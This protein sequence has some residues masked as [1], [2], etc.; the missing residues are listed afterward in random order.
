MVK[1]WFLVLIIVFFIASP[2]SVFGGSDTVVINAFRLR[3]SEKSTDEFVELLN[4]SND[5]ISL[6]GW[7][8]SKKNSSGTNNNLLTTFPE[9]TLEAGEK[10]TI[11]HRDFSGS[12]D[13]NYSTLSY[14][15]AEDNAIV[16]YADAGKTEVDKVGWGKSLIFEGAPLPNPQPDEIWE[17]KELGLD[18]DNN[19]A[20]FQLRDI[21]SN[22]SEPP[23]TE[24]GNNTETI[25]S[26]I[27][28]TELMPNPE[29]TDSGKEWVEFFNGGPDLNLAGYSLSDKFG[30][31]KT[32]YFPAGFSL[33]SEQYFVF[34]LKGTGISLNNDGDV[35]EIK[36][37]NGQIVAS[38]GP[39]YGTAKEGL[40]WAFNGAN[41]QW[42]KVPTPG[43][44][45][46]IEVPAV[47]VKTKTVKSK[48]VKKATLPKASVKGST[49]ATDDLFEAREQRVNENDKKIGMI[50]IVLALV[51]GLVYTVYTNWSQIREVYLA[52]RKKYHQIRQ[53][54]RQKTKK[55]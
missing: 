27:F 44:A 20:D 43:A 37:P 16:L 1:R 54:I 36:D 41:W 48:T 2:I 9:V 42:T 32:Y 12:F 45:N 26:N 28:I 6:S 47:A 23:V 51:G 19:A 18:T 22:P 38:S 11:A 31:V 49:T 13:L 3:T 14:S 29:G 30:S 53:K 35:L 52:K 8:L 10:I 33:A 34:P 15:L 24:P 39:N 50:L 40:A 7:R 21:V 46:I 4:V 17:R 25:V 55:G 5:A